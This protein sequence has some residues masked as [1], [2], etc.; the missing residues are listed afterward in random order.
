MHTRAPLTAL[1]AAITLG[2]LTAVPGGPAPIDAAFAAAPNGRLVVRWRQA[3]PSVLDD[4]GIASHRASPASPD[5]SVVVAK[6]GRAAEVA[7]RLQADPRVASVVPDAIGR[8]TEWPEAL[9]EPADPLWTQWQADMRRIGM[10]AAWSITTGSADVVVAVLD[11]GYERGHEDLETVPIVDR[12]NSR[13]GTTSVKDGYGH[14]THVAGT[15]AA[16]TNNDLGVASVA[17]G[18]TIMPVKVLDANGQGYWSDFLEGVDWAV[19]HGA[20]VI[21]MSLGSGLSAK[22]VAAWQPTFTRAWEAGTLVVAAAGNNDNNTP[23]YPASFANVVSVSATNNSDAKASFS[24]YG[25]AV[26]LSAPGVSIASTYRDN[27]Y[28]AMSGTSMATPHVAGLAALIRSI[29][30][31]FTPADVETGLKA[32]A[33]DLGK[34]GRDNIFGHGR[35]RAP[36]ALAWIPPDVTPP[37][38]SLAVPLAGAAAVAE[39][40]VPQIVFD[41]PVT[42]VDATSVRLRTS[43]GVWLDAAVTYDELSHVATLA[44]V[45]RLASSTAHVVVVDGAI[46]DLAGN[47]VTPG[48]FGFTTGDTIAPLV[49]DTNPDA[50]KDGV[51]RGVTVRV[52]LD[53]TVTG[54]SGET[55]RLRRLSSGDRVPA[56]VRWDPATRTISLDP[57][58]RLAAGRWYEVKIRAGIGDL[59]GNP[60]A[61]ATFTFRTR[62]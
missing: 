9:S 15:I 5:R 35:I 54:V 10:P 23:F 27:T 53:S 36:E 43:A 30:P 59:A 17:P 62:A 40:V 34:A 47:L 31:E 24:N 2:I 50:G 51:W 8:V 25:P 4:A 26:D 48:S 42:G 46:Q 41:E 3:A 58:R 56:T 19:D 13:T 55:L 38:A 21:N 11:T 29:H 45:A 33:L 44:P 57:N 14:G 7:A 12:Y 32:T 18:V 37:T 6:R 16:S 60:L 20:D 61:P 28:W 39:T 22:Q 49:V 52:V 1:L